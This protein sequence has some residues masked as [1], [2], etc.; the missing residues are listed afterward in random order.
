[1]FPSTPIEHPEETEEAALADERSH[2][3]HKLCVGHVRQP[4]E[5][6]VSGNHWDHCRGSRKST[7]SKPK[8]EKR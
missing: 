8:T 7:A 3:P 1:M 2:Q 6:C 5:V 4:S